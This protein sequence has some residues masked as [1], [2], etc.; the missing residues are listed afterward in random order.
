MLLEAQCRVDSGS[1]WDDFFVIFGFQ[2]LGNYYFA[3]FN[4][5]NDGGTH[6]IFKIESGFMTE[7]V[8]FPDL[9]IKGGQF[10]D[11]EIERIGLLIVARKNGV[12]M[13]SVADPTFGGGLIG[14]GS[15]NNPV[16]L[17]DLVVIE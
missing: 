4:E 12:V 11:I 2:D 13:G 17:D 14:F 7:L 5:L 1:A 16:R 9:T 8:D 3:S 10:Y 15:F 6:G